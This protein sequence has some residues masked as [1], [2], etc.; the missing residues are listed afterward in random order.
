MQITFM[1][2]A[3]A[4][5]QQDFKRRHVQVEDL[6]ICDVAVQNSLLAPFLCHAGGDTFTFGWGRNCHRAFDRPPHPL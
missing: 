4:E 1:R 2:K 6:L 5:Y 3:Y